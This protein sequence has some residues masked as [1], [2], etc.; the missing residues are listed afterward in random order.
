MRKSGRLGTIVSALSLC[1]GVVFFSSGCEKA[2]TP[3]PVSLTKRVI[4]PAVTSPSPRQVETAKKEPPFSYD[5][6]GKVDP[7]KPFIQI[8]PAAK[9]AQGIPRTPLQEYD[10]S[11][12]KLTAII[13]MDNDESRALVEDSAGK[14]FTIRK[15]TYIGKRGG[16]VTEVLKDGVV[17][18]EL[19]GNYENQEK[20]KKVVMKM[21]EEGGKR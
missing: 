8:G 4:K 6:Q 3:P 11:Q 2:S 18:E 16:K 9:V 13:W 12:L 10:L 17:V 5:P 20:A 1:I 7:F 21:P 19:M 15:G 14:G